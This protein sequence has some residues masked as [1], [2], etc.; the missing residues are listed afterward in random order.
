MESFKLKTPTLRFANARLA[1]VSAGSTIPDA[2]H[3]QMV[4]GA[5]GGGGLVWLTNPLEAVREAA[6]WPQLCSAPVLRVRRDDVTSR[7]TPSADLRPLGEDVRWRRLNVLGTS[8]WS[9]WKP[10]QFCDVVVVWDSGVS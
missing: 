6:L 7:W 5:G 3:H 1:Q 4:F 8:D 9:L 2:W 10:F